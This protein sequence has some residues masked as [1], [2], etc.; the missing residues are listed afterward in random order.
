M[1]FGAGRADDQED[2]EEALD[3]SSTC[4]VFVGANGLSPW[5]N[6]E[7]RTALNQRAMSKSLRII[8][9]LLPGSEP[10]KGHSLPR[11]LQRFTWVDFREGVESSDQFKD[12]LL[13]LRAK[14]RVELR[15]TRF[16]L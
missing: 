6:E 7:M 14:L 13:V 15:R 8:P 11:F 9:V 3:A 5:E 12:S 16:L 1:A 10:A 2:L 4:A